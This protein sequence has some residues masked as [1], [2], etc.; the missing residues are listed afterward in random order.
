M[1][2]A[3]K[4]TDATGHTI[5]HHEYAYADEPTIPEVSG[6]LLLRADP[7]YTSRECMSEERAEAAFHGVV[8]LLAPAI[9]AELSKQ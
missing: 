9:G 6:W 1:L 5:L 8:P 7:K 3:A 2:I 4:L